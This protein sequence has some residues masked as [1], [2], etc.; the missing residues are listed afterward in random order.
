MLKNKKVLLAGVVVVAALSFTAGV[1]TM[2]RP[3][4]IGGRTFPKIIGRA[5]RTALWFLL[6]GESRKVEQKTY[7]HRHGEESTDTISHYAGW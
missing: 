4:I 2:S 6:M 5:A 7:V 1:T 3:A